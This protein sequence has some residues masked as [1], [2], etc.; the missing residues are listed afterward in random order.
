M[1]AETKKAAKKRPYR[2]RLVRK[3]PKRFGICVDSLQQIKPAYLKRAAT[4][5]SSS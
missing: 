1:A 3:K 2:K 4:V 5:T